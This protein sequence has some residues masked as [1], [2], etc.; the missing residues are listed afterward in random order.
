MLPWAR[1]IGSDPDPVNEMSAE[2]DLDPVRL[3]ETAD[4]ESLRLIA[5]AGQLLEPALVLRLG[6]A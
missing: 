6:P 1:I 2:E 4:H 5:D 3:Q